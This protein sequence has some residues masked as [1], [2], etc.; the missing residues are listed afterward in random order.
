MWCFRSNSFRLDLRD[1]I[2]RSLQQP[3][4]FLHINLRRGIVLMPHHF[5]HTH[6][7][8]VIEERKGRSRMP[9]TMDDDTGFFTPAK[10]SPSVMIR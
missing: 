1:C 7:I 8:R 4:Y 2:F 10:S 5:L 9:Q 3:L 6:R